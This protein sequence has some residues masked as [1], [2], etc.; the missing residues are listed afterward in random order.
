[1][2][3]NISLVDKFVSNLEGAL[4]KNEADI[5]KH[6]Y[7]S[8]QMIQTSFLKNQEKRGYSSK[9]KFDHEN[10]TIAIKTKSLSD[11]NFIPLENLSGGEKSYCQVSFLS[12][13]WESLNCPF[14]CLDEFDVFLDELNRIS[15][16]DSL[17]K[18]TELHP[19]HQYIFITPYELKSEL[20]ISNARVFDC[21]PFHPKKTVGLQNK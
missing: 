17:I 6:R 18:I 20:S 11:Q 12:S 5:D 21:N 3:N 15:A 19:E 16:I 7:T 13:M 9:L 2:L 14:F 1:M 10:Q 4:Q 8:S